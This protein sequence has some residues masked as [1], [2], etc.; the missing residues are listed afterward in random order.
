VLASSPQVKALDGKYSV[1]GKVIS[2][3]DVVQKLVVTDVIRRATVRDEA[4]AGR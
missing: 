4:P 1:F 3:M 2:G